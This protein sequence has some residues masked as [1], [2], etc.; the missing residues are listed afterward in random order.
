[1]IGL[2]TGR[3]TT[4]RMNGLL[5]DLSHTLPHAK[6][7]RRGK[8]SLNDLSV[9]LLNE[10]ITHAIIINRW[11]GTPGRLTLYSVQ[12]KGVT[13]LM[14]SIFLSEIKLNREYKNHTRP[15]VEGITCGKVKQTTHQFSEILSDV[16]EI[17]LT[18][19]PT[20]VDTTFHLVQINDSIR[21]VVTSPPMEREVGPCLTISRLLWQDTGA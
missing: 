15:T 2:T 18:Q 7:V 1:M 21:F 11:H 4:Q 16:F 20:D 9:K 8:S 10:N 13:K 12:P 6:I 3:Q 19:N 17:P 14:P 5:K